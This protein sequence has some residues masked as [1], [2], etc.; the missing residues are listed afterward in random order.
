MIGKILRIGGL[1][2]IGGFLIALLI[3]NTLESSS[4]EPVWDER[5]TIGSKEA[6]NHFIMYTDIMCPYCDVFS[7]EIMKNEAEFKKEYI[8][9]KDILFEVR[10]TDF[11][12]QYGNK[13]EYSKQS[14]EASYCAKEENK[15]WQFYHEALASL[16]R[17]Y[18]SKGIGVS[19]NSPAIANLPADYWLKIGEKVG[20]KKKFQNCYNNHEKQN[21][22]FRAT[23][24]AAEIIGGGLPY[25]K[26]NNFTNNGFDQNW[27]WEYVKY[28]L[29]AGL[30]QR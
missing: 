11:L 5:T 25:F 15:F 26:F 7:R 22:V 8:E 3:F 13:N 2:L 10:V 9:Q 20:L 29:D 21:E 28:F 30:K 23:E 6:K 27:G 18:H 17:D 12:Y 14:A 16:W 4:S 24:K 19:K 1:V